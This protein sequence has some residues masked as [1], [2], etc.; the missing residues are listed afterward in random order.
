MRISSLLLSVPL[1][2]TVAC[3]STPPEKPKPEPE[4][5][6][7]IREEFAKILE[8]NFRGQLSL[9]DGKGYFKA[10]DTN[11]E[12]P[13]DANFTLRNIYEQ[14]SASKYTPVYVEFTG[15]IIFP[16][17]G[18][19]KSDAA[20]RIDRVH[21]MALAK[22]SLQC[23]KPVDTFLFNANGDDPYWR[24]NIND[25]QLFFATKAR[26]QAYNVK[27]SNFRT[28]QINNIST[29]NEQGQRLKLTIEPGHCYNLKNKE[30][31]GYT[32]KVDTV[33]GEFNGCGEPG[34]PIS[35]LV[36]TGFYLNKTESKTTDLTLNSNYTV[37]YKETVGGQS[38]TKTGFWKSNSP[39]RV[40]IMLTRRENKQIREEINFNRSGLTLASSR[41]NTN[42]IITEF[43]ASGLIFNK[44][45]APEG[46][47]EIIDNS[48]K[49]TFTSQRIGPQPEVDREVQKAVNQYFKIHRTD[50]K[51]TKFS[52]VKFDL[53]GDGIKDAVVLLD[54]CSKSG[55]EMLIFEGT[56][57]GYRFSSRVS[58][59]QAPIIVAQSQHYLW[60]SLLTEKNGEWLKLD[61]DGISYPIHTSELNSVDK[62]AYSTG[63]VL[64][65]QGTPTN[66]F[67]IKM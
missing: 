8:G 5:K 35:D 61:F 48:I 58:R 13:V 33:W 20:M 3:S 63:V 42:N 57:K 1:F 10:C 18:D 52:S 46:D 43:A 62:G 64:F 30:Y 60:Q 17:K 27:H 39:D 25:Q 45:N 37:E 2:L 50:P 49:R 40:V 26:N 53:N 66:W 19:K 38:T 67:P 22:A 32:T 28:T 9:G 47:V 44:M 4:Q 36:F 29:T 41:I 54:W 16:A 51:N 6:Q 55:C 11:E 56:E 59:I 31:W 23:A 14:I 24:L 7:V 15:E 65:N 34:W 12:F 21:H